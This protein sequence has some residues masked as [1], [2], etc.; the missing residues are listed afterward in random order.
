MSAPIDVSQ[1]RIMYGASATGPWATI[2]DGRTWE[3]THGSEG[4]TTIPVFGAAAYVR[5]GN[6]TWAGSF[7]AL[8]R[9][10]DASQQALRTAH[11]GRTS[12]FI[13]FVHDPTNGSEKGYL[14]QCKVTEFSESADAGGDYVEA[15]FTLVG[16]GA[17]VPFTG[18]LPS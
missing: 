5:Q 13:L 15:S 1:V 17:R 11:D 9:P 8:F 3:G 18:G 6:N 10:D 12:V 16:E 14:Q 2:A 7:S 4:E